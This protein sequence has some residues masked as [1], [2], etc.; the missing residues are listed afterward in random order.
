MT[1]L[2]GV[3]IEDI[4]GVQGLA[5]EVPIALRAEAY[6][7]DV[8]VKYPDPAASM[9][10][11]GLM[12][13]TESASRTVTLVNSGKYGVTYSI[14]VRNPSMKELFGIGPAEGSL[15]PG[16]QQ[17]VELSFNKYACVVFTVYMPHILATGAHCCLCIRTSNCV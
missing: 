17:A 2:A 11:I 15:A 7:I 6:G 13:A 8:A 14:Q 3:Q 16:A 5:Q 12:K 10:D 9:L 1:W 4:G